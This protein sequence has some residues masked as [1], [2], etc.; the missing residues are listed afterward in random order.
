M[1]LIDTTYLNVKE[2]TGINLEGKGNIHRIS[3]CL[4]IIVNLKFQP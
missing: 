2:N 4:N 3:Y 1:F